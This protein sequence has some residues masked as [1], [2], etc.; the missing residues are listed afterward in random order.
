MWML[1]GDKLE[2]ATCIAKSS[3]LVAR[4][5]AVHI[6]KSVT[7]RSDAHQELNA[8]RRKQDAALVIKGDAMEVDLFQT[9]VSEAACPEVSKLLGVP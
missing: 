1:T 7:S 2:T 6:F 3:Q 5:Q 4:T 8:F 9:E